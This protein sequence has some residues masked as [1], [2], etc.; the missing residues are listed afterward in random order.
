M[1]RFAVRA[2]SPQIVSASSTDQKVITAQG[3]SVAYS[4]TDGSGTLTAGQSVTVAN[5][6]RVSVSSGRANVVVADV[7]GSPDTIS[8]ASLPRSVVTD[9]EKDAPNGVPQ[10]NGSGLLARS[11]VTPTPASQDELNNAVQGLEVDGGVGALIEAKGDLVIGSGPAAA[12]RLAPPDTPGLVP[13][14]DPDAPNLLSWQK[15]VTPDLNV[16]NAASSWWTLPTTFYVGGSVRTTY[17]TAVGRGGDAIVGAYN[18]RTETCEIGRLP[19]KV[20]ADDHCAPALSMRVRDSADRG[21]LVFTN[22][23]NLNNVIKVSRSVAAY[24]VTEWAEPWEI[25]FPSQVS[26]AQH[27]Y[28][29]ATGRHWLFVRVLTTGYPWYVTTSTDDG[30]TWTT[31]VAF[32][33][34]GDDNQSY[35]TH[36]PQFTG[37]GHLSI[38]LYGHPDLS[39]IPE[40]RQVTLRTSDGAVLTRSGGVTTEVAN[41]LTN[42]NLPI[43]HTDIPAAYEP[44]EGVK[45]RLFDITAVGS[46]VVIS[47]CDWTDPS[48]TADYKLAVRDPDGAWTIVDLG[49]STG[50]RF[51]ERESAHYHGGFFLD[52]RATNGYLN[53][54]LAREDGGTW[55][56]EQWRSAS[57]YTSWELVETLAERDDVPLARPRSVWSVPAYQGEEEFRALYHEVP[58]YPLTENAWLDFMMDLKATGP[59]EPPIDIATVSGLGLWLRAS[60][61]AASNGDLIQTWP[62]LSGN[63]RHATQA[64]S[65]VRATFTTGGVNGK[66]YLLFGANPWYDIA[67]LG[68][69]RNVAGL[70]V[71]SVR[72]LLSGTST[73]RILLHLSSGASAAAARVRLE[74]ARTSGQHSM[75]GRRLDAD[76]AAFV[77]GGTLQDT[78]TEIVTNV[79]DYANATAA[80]RV[81]GVQ[82]A[83]GAFQ[84]AGSTSDT[85]AVAQKLGASGDNNDRWS[86]YIYEVIVV[87]RAM[88]AGEIAQVESALAAEYARTL[89]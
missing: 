22:D 20:R 55:T 63:E 58:R 62:D 82:V 10:L 60:S 6:T 35:M 80:I 13:A 83:S 4:N 72:R 25:T 7:F 38:A 65:G 3:G 45:T 28:D 9:S 21:P 23:H 14:F 76:S 40:I 8:E 33:A 29:T 64:T 26:Y 81:N 78:A 42:T 43:D 77:Q 5:D 32:L 89:G 48:A 18:H 56:V 16:A 68:L 15:R 87:R 74:A 2:G 61:L 70:T 73:L 71:F 86:G 75:G 27:Y 46:R 88:T 19:W 51:G 66:P 17:F 53:G 57:P 30:D 37:E 79:Y 52:A 50:E 67:G 11:K 84:T 34:Y 47:F 12:T 69:S 36:K 39:E 41:V 85:D 49:V 54:Y 31:P 1:S 44:D 24:N 59:P